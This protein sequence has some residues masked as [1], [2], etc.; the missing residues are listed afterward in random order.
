[1]HPAD[2]QRGD[3]DRGVDVGG[4]GQATRKPIEVRSTMTA[5]NPEL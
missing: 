2:D 4:A 1:M 3:R 5:A